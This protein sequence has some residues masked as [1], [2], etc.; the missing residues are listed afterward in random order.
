MRADQLTAAVATHG[1]G[2]VWSPTWGGLCWVDMLAGDVLRLDSSGSI[3]RWHVGRAVAVLRPRSS[4]GVVL[5]SEDSLLVAD[6]LGG[7]LVTLASPL[8]DPDQRFNEG[9]CAPDG[10]FLCGTTSW[11]HRRGRAGVYRLEPSGRVT[12]V[13][14]GVT[15]SNGLAWSSDGATGYYV[16]SGTG[17]ID[18]FDTDLTTRRPYV[19]LDPAHGVPDGLTTDVDGGVW[20]ALWQG[21]AVHRYDASGALSEVITLPVSQVTSCTFGGDDHCDLF[22]TTSRHE[23]AA[24]HPAAG[25]VFRV[26]TGVRGTPVLPFLG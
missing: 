19:T 12:T 4:G 1:E 11:S 8:T 3:D 15:T 22:V 2:A 20:V 10:A 14:T 24:P 9:G 23:E 5:A 13:L 18:A 21:G 7:E 6:R 26:S 16:D 17:R 25:S